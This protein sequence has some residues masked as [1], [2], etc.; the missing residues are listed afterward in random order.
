MKDRVRLGVDSLFPHLPP[1]KPLQVS[2][3]GREIHRV[4]QTH[5]E[6]TP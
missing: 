3:N 5:P 1:T 4:G 2:G 6:Y